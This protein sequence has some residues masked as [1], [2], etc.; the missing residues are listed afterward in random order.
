MKKLEKAK[1]VN[2]N[3][4]KNIT[5]KNTLMFCLINILLGIK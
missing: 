3:V 4:I 2:E 5:H 1:G